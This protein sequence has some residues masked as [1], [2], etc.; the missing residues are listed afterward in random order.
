MRLHR[1]N[2][3]PLLKHL[4]HQPQSKYLLHLP[5]LKHLLLPLHQP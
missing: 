2:P 5:L 3:Q 1:R 4:L